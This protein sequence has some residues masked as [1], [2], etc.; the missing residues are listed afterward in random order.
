VYLNT[1]NKISFTKEKN[2]QSQVFSIA[3]QNA[4]RQLLL[5]D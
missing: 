2:I 3:T 4:L 5:L 1:T